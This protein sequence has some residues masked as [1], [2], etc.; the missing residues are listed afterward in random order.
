MSA[1]HKLYTRFARQ[2]LPLLALVFILTAA[3]SLWFTHRSELA[4]AQA[5]RSQ[6]L[7]VFG[8]A[9]VKPLWDCDSTTTEAVIQALLEQPSI[10]S[11]EVHDLCNV[12]TWRAGATAPV[13][14]ENTLTLPLVHYPQSGNGHDLGHLSIGFAPLSLNTTAA[15]N[16]GLQLIVFAVM[17]IAVLLGSAWIFER[18][19]GRP[20]DRLRAAMHRQQVLEP[21]PSRWAEELVEI[22]QTYN[23]QVHAL[24]RQARHD[25]LTGLGNRTLLEERLASALRRAERTRHCGHLLLLDLNRFK[26]INDTHGHAA[27][28]Y[29]LQ[30]LALRLQ[31][32]MRQT[33]TVVRLGGDEFVILAPEVTDAAA[34]AA[35]CQRITQAIAQPVPWQGL[36]LRISAS[37]GCAQLLRHGHDSASLLVH[38]DGQMYANKPQER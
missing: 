26:P 14:P 16:L 31:D 20:L 29:V 28:D 8:A 38:A 12:K 22:T 11:I 15:H 7:V 30:T 1:H 19:I 4:S 9:L 3:S 2:L 5:Q 27:G 36:Q 32:G 18:I 34:L 33:D 23:T 6:T 21:I 13:Q 10:H 17:L 37:I 25:A 35:L 24:R